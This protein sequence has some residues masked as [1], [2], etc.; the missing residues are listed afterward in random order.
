MMQAAKMLEP[1]G[2]YTVEL[3]FFGHDLPCH[4]LTKISF[5]NALTMFDPFLK[6]NIFEYSLGGLLRF[7]E[8]FRQFHP[9]F[10]TG[11]TGG[12][13]GTSRCGITIAASWKRPRQA[14]KLFI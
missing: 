6:H 2:N 7:P 12:D 10:L 5:K 4:S 1:L 8:V 9:I 11:F 14:S 13:H 3:D